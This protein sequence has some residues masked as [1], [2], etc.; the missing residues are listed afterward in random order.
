MDTRV[1]AGAGSIIPQRTPTG[2]SSGVHPQAGRATSKG[3]NEG[4]AR[5]PERSPPSAEQAVS[6]SSDSR[7][8]EAAG[9]QQGSPPDRAWWQHLSSWLGLR[10]SILGSD[11]EVQ[12]PSQSA[13]SRGQH[14]VNGTRPGAVQSA[15]NLKLPSDRRAAE[16]VT[17]MHDAFMLGHRSRRLEC[18]T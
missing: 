16:G 1:A 2:A 17:S 3:A 5:L 10:S 8:L 11:Q 9:Q 13:A 14:R 12:R 18:A 6:R 4:P 7:A 15:E